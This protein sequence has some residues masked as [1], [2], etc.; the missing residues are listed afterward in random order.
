MKCSLIFMK[1][2]ENL[3]NYINMPLIEL[4]EEIGLSK[5]MESKNCPSELVSVHICSL[6]KI[7][8]LYMFL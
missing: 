5:F 8:F 1:H 4:K 3:L 2:K 7:Y 6:L